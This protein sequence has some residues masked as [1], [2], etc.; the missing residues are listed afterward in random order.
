LTVHEIRAQ[1]V[2]HIVTQNV[3]ARALGED[4]AEAFNGYV[5]RSALASELFELADRMNPTVPFDPN[6]GTAGQPISVEGRERQRA[7][8]ADSNSNQQPKGLF[9]RQSETPRTPPRGLG[10]AESRKS[11]RDSSGSF[12]GL[13]KS[14]KGPIRQAI[15]PLF[16]SPPPRPSPQSPGSLPCVRSSPICSP[17]TAIPDLGTL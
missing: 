6:A 15:S 10:P 1:E 17:Q 11:G 8:M 3:R 13:S 12:R 2:C 9:D 16:F 4:R 5:A 14:P 7:Q